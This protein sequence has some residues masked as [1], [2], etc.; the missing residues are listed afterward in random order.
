VQVS[1]DYGA[2][3]LFKIDADLGANPLGEY[4]FKNNQVPNNNG[5]RTY[6]YAAKGGAMC[7]GI[8]I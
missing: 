8:T 5:V 2:R 1:V 6:G 7:Y 3:H 4:I